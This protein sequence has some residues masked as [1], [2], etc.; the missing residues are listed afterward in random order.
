MMVAARG[1]RVDVEELVPAEAHAREEP[2]VECPLCH[3]DVAG[4]AGGQEQAM[5]PENHRQRCAGFA[6][7]FLVR[8][9][10]VG[11]EAFMI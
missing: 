8:Q 7:G 4:I 9:I 2:V 5:A 10:V 1:Q 11:G 3:I 6:V